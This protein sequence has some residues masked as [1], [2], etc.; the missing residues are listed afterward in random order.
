M[1]TQSMSHIVIAFKTLPDY[2]DLHRESLDS[3]ARQS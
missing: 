1:R 3:I 2:D